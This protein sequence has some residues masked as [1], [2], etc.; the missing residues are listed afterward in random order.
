MIEGQSVENDMRCFQRAWWSSRKGLA[1]QLIAFSSGIAALCIGQ[2][3]L[4]LRFQLP[5][6]VA[7][8]VAVALKVALA[9]YVPVRTETSSG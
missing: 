1:V 6:V 7:I 2:L 5:L 4:R 9:R 8:L 3:V